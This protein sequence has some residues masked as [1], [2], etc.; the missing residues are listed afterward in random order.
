MGT[1]HRQRSR[2]YSPLHLGKP[3]R[4]D[5]RNNCQA[6]QRLRLRRTHRQRVSCNAMTQYFSSS[7][8]IRW[9]KVVAKVFSTLTNA[10]SAEGGKQ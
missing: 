4:S 2:R 7:G 1:L 9:R 10:E 3:V 5:G 8:R 6:R